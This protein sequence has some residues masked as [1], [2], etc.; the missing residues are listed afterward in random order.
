MNTS[1][2]LLV[3]GIYLPTTILLTI[4]TA[5][6]LFKSGE[7]F[8]LD[9]FKGRESIARATNQLFKMGFYLLN[10]GFALMMLESNAYITN[11]QEMLEVTSLKVGS[12]S[13]YLGVMLFLNMY[14]FFRGKKKSKQM[15]VA[16][17]A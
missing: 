8:M 4:Y 13:I 14:L 10:L 2:V 11:S 9:I 17:A 16:P 7:I 6:V 15:N 1:H 3:Y 12:F 5:K